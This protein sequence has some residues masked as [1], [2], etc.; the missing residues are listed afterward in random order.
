MFKQVNNWAQQQVDIT[1]PTFV[2]DEMKDKAVGA[3]NTL[4]HNPRV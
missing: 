1:A 2:I 4:L 3:T